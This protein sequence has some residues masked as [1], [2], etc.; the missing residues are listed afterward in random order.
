[1]TDKLNEISFMRFGEAPDAC[2]LI[3]LNGLFPPHRGMM[4]GP[5]ERMDGADVGIL[6]HAYR[7]AVAVA[8]EGDVTEDM[9]AGIQ[10]G[11]LLKTMAFLAGALERLEQ[12]PTAAMMDRF[13]SLVGKSTSHFSFFRVLPCPAVVRL[14]QVAGG[15]H[16]GAGK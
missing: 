13:S 15:R 3:E 2:F 9:G 11:L 8:I 6:V 1:M 4:R 16:T 10:Q 12:L 5:A 7:Y 14:Y